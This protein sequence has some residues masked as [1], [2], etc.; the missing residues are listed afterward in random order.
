MPLQEL[1]LLDLS[2]M[3]K[4]FF[5]PGALSTL[6]RLHIEEPSFLQNPHADRQRLLDHESALERAAEQIFQLPE[7]YQIS[8]HCDL[9][10]CAMKQVL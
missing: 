7:L 9:F 4:V 10:K 5:V 6:R 1:V 3:E 8:G 2:G